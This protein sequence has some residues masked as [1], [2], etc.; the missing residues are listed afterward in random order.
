MILVIAPSRLGSFLSFKRR[1][2]LE[3]LVSFTE[4]V[5]LI[6]YHQFI[7]EIFD[8]RSEQYKDWQ[9]DDWL[10]T[11]CI[12]KLLSDNVQAWFDERITKAVTTTD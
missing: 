4:A 3:V 12:T 2:P 9:K 7:E 10:C 11:Q 5:E 6:P 8:I 1:R